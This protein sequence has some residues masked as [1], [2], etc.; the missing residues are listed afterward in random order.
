MKGGDL[1]WILREPAGT[2]LMSY[3][4]DWQY[5]PFSSV[6]LFSMQ[7]IDANNVLA[8]ILQIQSSENGVVLMWLF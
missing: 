7:L 6:L 1:L 2:R 5:I 8:N 4:H 3:C